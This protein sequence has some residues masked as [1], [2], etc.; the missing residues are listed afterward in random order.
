MSSKTVIFLGILAAILLNYFCVRYHL[1][2]L[3]DNNLTIRDIKNQ[4][5]SEPIPVALKDLDE[6]NE[7]NKSEIVQKNIESNTT[8]KQEEDEIDR[9]IRS[10]IDEK[11]QEINE[12]S[13]NLEHVSSSN[14]SMESDTNLTKA[15]EIESEINKKLLSTPIEFKF[16]SAVLT[17]KSKKILREIATELK[18]LDLKNMEIEVAGYTDAKGNKYFN[19]ELSLKRAKSVRRYLIK[20]GIDKN[21]IKAVGYGESNFIYDKNDKRNRRV[22]IHIKRGQ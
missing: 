12:T 10:L 7:T 5:K 9:Q 1:P 8:K 3:M 21:I 15:K 6:D 20:E 16:S 2:S 22:E 18:K 13:T 4:E 19:K 11:I 14:K 17:R